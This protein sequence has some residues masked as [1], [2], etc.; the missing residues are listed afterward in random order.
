M[1]LLDNWFNKKLS[2]NKDTIYNL[3][4]Y[5]FNNALVDSRWQTNP[6]NIFTRTLLE[7]S[8][9][10]SGIVE[11]L[12]YFYK[13]TYP[14]MIGYNATPVISYFWHKVTPKTIM[15]HSGIPALISKT[16]VSLI[17]APGINYEV[18]D[19]EEATQRLFEI[20]QDNNF[21]DKLLP[22]GVI[23]ESYGGFFGFKISQDDDISQY[24]IIELVVPENMEVMQERGRV[25]GFIFKQ[26]MKEG[27]D[28]IE[29]HEI[30]R[31][32]NIDQTEIMY[33]KY[34][35]RDGKQVEIDFEPNEREE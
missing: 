24:P 14:K 3:M 35:Y 5:R 4:E 27:N 22:D 25:T 33:K 28:D 31:K 34:K 21:E 9:W 13:I 6:E 7:N 23:Y 19:N 26:Y 2:R 12:N 8:K 1:A 32:V 15:V 30:Y 18:N 29:I 20:L 16:M 17:A 11:E 10:Q